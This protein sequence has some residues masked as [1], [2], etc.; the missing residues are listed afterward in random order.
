[1]N[2]KLLFILL[3]VVS[4]SVFGCKNG[5]MECSGTSAPR[6]ICESDFIEKGDFQNYIS[7]Y[8]TT[9]GVCEEN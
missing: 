3:L 8:E 5:C 9:G 2:N 7:A 6:E 1:M 4:V